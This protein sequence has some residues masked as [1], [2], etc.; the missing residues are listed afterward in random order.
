[1]TQSQRFLLALS[2]CAMGFMMLY[3]G[4]TKV[5]DPQWSALGYLKG[6]KAMVGFYTLLQHPSILPVIDFVNAWGLTLLGVSLILGIGVRIAAPFGALLM[7]LYYIP[8]GFPYPNPHA[9]IVDEHI[10]YAT[11]LLYFAA[12]DAGAYWG[13]SGVLKKTAVGKIPVVGKVV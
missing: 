13:L 2:R 10:I 12:V 8:L 11:I 9:L 1:M 7:V 4:I 5:M 3:A 6:A